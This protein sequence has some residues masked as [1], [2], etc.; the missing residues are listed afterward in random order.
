MPC[1]S[2][3]DSETDFVH[4]LEVLTVVNIANALAG[5]YSNITAEG[6]DRLLRIGGSGDL[7]YQR[8]RWTRTHASQFTPSGLRA[9]ARLLSAYKALHHSRVGDQDFPALQHDLSLAVAAVME[10]V[11]QRQLL[12]AW[13]P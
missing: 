8:E 6:I 3:P 12:T 5:N 7:V 10:L 9:A 13:A 2:S 1:N 11:H 4:L